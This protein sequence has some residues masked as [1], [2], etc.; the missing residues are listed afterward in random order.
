VRRPELG[1]QRARDFPGWGPTWWLFVILW[2]AGQDLSL[3]EPADHLEC[4][5]GRPAAWLGVGEAA[6]SMTNR[7]WSSRSKKKIRSES[8]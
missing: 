4:L 8:G 6:P 2:M 7:S 3:G 1:K 5:R